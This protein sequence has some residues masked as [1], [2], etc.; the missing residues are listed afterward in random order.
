M[1]PFGIEIFYWRRT[2]KTQGKFPINLSNSLN[3]HFKRGNIYMKFETQ[4]S[5]NQS[6]ATPE[7][8]DAWNTLQ[9]NLLGSK[10]EPV[11]KKDGSVVE[12]AL[13]K[14]KKAVGIPRVIIDCGLQPQKDAEYD[15]KGV[16]GEG[17]SPDG[18]SDEEKAHV[19][20]YADNYFKTVDG[21]RKQ[22]K[23]ERP[24]QEV[25][26]Y[27][28]FPKL[29]VDYSQHPNE[30]LHELGEQPL[31]ECINGYFKDTKSGY[32]GFSRKFKFDPHWKTGKLSPNSPLYKLA[33][34]LGVAEEFE[35]SGYDFDVLGKGAAMFEVV[36]TKRNGYVNFE[37]KG[38]S[39]IIDIEAGDQVITRESQIPEIAAPFKTLM[40]NQSSYE[41]K[42]LVKLINYKKELKV[43][44]PEMVAFQPN[45][46]KNPD[47]WLGCNW[48]D[49]KLKKELD[50]LSEASQAS[51]QAQSSSEGNESSKESKAPEKA[52]VNASKPVDSLPEE[53]IDFNDDIPF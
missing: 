7:Q 28:D 53:D 29:L 38:H 25:A 16:A 20:K 30:N 40:I 45:S 9:W 23:P 24:T 43:T 44:L 22:Y 8:W 13:K 42:E 52:V 32:E 10:E 4:T 27:I 19:A 41:D 18:Y 21:Q 14:V 12:G 11:T 33:K 48:E 2:N 15:W 34:S 37:I 3:G 26:I 51:Q 1:T 46:V 47:F 36:C 31:R 50:S 5:G 39:E 17:D 35:S 49:T 6:S